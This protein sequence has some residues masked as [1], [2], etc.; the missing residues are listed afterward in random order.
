[1]EGG[2]GAILERVPGWGAGVVFALC[3]HVDK[4][5]RYQSAYS[6]H[7][8]TLLVA[9]LSHMMRNYTDCHGESACAVAG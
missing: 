5:G 1:M 3:C 2:G 6:Y 8:E 7:S 9:S 4:G